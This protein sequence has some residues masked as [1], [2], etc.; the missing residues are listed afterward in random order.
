MV[1]VECVEGGPLHSALRS[2]PTKVIHINAENRLQ[3][4][5]NHL[6]T[7]NAPGEVPVQ[8][9]PNHGFG[10]PHFVTSGHRLS[11]VH[12]LVGP[13]VRWLVPGLGWSVWSVMWAF[14]V[15]VMQDTIF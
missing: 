5:Q 9:R 4:D 14:F 7:K 11:L 3:E 15:C 2:V 8:V 1:F 13:D 6:P 10:R 12:Y